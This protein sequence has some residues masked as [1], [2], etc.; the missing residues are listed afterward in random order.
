MKIIECE[1]HPRNKA[2]IAVGYE[3][4]LR[5]GELASLRIKNIK[6]EYTWC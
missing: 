2:I 4:G 3:A 5:I 1:E 6:L